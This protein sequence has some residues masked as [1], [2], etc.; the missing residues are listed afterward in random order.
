MKKL[1]TQ[2]S[3]YIIDRLMELMNTEVGKKYTDELL[4]AMLC[5]QI[6]ELE[7]ELATEREMT[8]MSSLCDNCA[9]VGCIFQAG[10]EREKCAFYKN[11]D[12]LFCKSQ[13]ITCNRVKECNGVCPFEDA[14]KHADRG[15]RKE[16]R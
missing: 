15:G 10:I 6:N 7:G 16:R 14:L 5:I 1:T 11:K 13:L 9:T 4:I 8:K 12:D 3:S 2:E